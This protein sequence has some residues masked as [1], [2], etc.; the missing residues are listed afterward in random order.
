MEP[1]FEPVPGPRYGEP[2]YEH[3]RDTTGRELRRQIRIFNGMPK[4][5]SVTQ[6]LINNCPLL[7]LLAAI[8]H[9]DPSR[10]FRMIHYNG[11]PKPRKVMFIGRDVHNTP[12]KYFITVKFQHRAIEITP[13]LY[14]ND[15]MQ[16]R[17]G[18]ADDG[19][20]PDTGAGWVSYIE[21]A[22]VVHRA[23][24][25]YD[26]LNL[27]ED[28]VDALAVS[29]V[30]E[31]VANDYDKLQIDGPLGTLDGR[32]GT[33][34]TDLEPVSPDPTPGAREAFVS[35]ATDARG[36]ILRDRRGRPLVQDF[37]GRNA[38]TNMRSRAREMLQQA[39]TRPTIATD[40]NH[41]KAVLEFRNGM[42][43]LFDPIPNHV[44]RT[45]TMS[46]DD[47]MASHDGIY[48]VTRPPRSA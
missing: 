1:L 8:A 45:P 4:A 32:T 28:Q 38:M 6:Q 43:T 39:T 42:V 7:A 14:R 3:E 31:D 21:K 41:T 36:R 22:Y 20:W 30:V 16:P 29:R 34:F 24:G 12:T 47:F 10:L 27:S 18:F 25:R 2:D 48:Q 33:F 46:L 5:Q 44:P 9:A 26:N 11:L 17:F 23:N 19:V 40:F 35:A 13:W 15:V 37:R